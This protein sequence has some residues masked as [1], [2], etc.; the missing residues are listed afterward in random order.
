MILTEEALETPFDS[1]RLFGR[2]GPF[3]I[4]IG[5]GK[6]RFL[7]EYASAHPD[8]NLLGVER[9]AKW[10]RHADERLE[11]AGVTNVRLLNIR[12]EDLLSRHLAPQSVDAFHIYFPD[13]W[14]KARH[15]KRR[16]FQ[17][18]FIL[19]LRRTL[20]RGGLVHL[21]TDHAAYFE[22]IRSSFCGPVAAGLRLVMGEKGPY[23]SNFQAKYEVEG[24][25]IAYA[26][27]KQY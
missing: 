26:T 5:V 4:E 12:A 25:S 1:S 16:L 2:P 17:P 23:V 9:I 22:E 21:A 13:P 7:R 3:E 27:V 14:P 10:L 8:Y 24:R 11:K 19:Q 15:N 6:G 18:H 20:K